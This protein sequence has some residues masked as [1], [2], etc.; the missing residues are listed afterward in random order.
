MIPHQ[1]RVYSPYVSPNDPCP[2]IQ[3]KTYVVPPNLFIDYQPTNL[4]QYSP[5]EALQK[6]TL[7]PLLFSPYPANPSF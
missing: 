1:Q 4:P 2:P 5:L 6:G 3:Y 7:W